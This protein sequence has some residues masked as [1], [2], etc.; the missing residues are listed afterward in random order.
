MANKNKKKKSR[1]MKW[2][3]ECLEIFEAMDKLEF[4]KDYAKHWC[5][6]HHHDLMGV[7]FDMCKA[8]KGKEVLA[9]FNE[10]VVK[11]QKDIAA[12]KYKDMQE[13]NAKIKRASLSAADMREAKDAAEAKKEAA[14]AKKT[15]AEPK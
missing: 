10:T 5:K 14:A 11:K 2:P 6:A 3:P 15:P 8:G 7:P 4:N 12:G 1:K 9:F 13:K